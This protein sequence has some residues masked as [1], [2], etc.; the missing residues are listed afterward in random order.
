MP[1]LDDGYP[2]PVWGAGESQAALP[3]RMD[4]VV[5]GA[6]DHAGLEGVPVDAQAPTPVQELDALVLVVDL[7]CK[8]QCSTP[9]RQHVSDDR[10]QALE[11]GQQ[12]KFGRL[13]AP[14]VGRYPRTAH[15]DDQRN[16]LRLKGQGL[17]EHSGPPT[18]RR[19][20]R[21]SSHE[22]RA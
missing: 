3:P 17:V 20:S 19:N 6:V 21:L 7:A 2:L 8:D 9:D 14:G 13:A 16:R 4:E 18:H 11:V 1:S 22:K 10:V 12:S 5:V 15:R